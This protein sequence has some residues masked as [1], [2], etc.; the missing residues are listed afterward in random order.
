MS[1]AFGNATVKCANDEWLRFAP[2]DGQTCA[3]YLETFMATAGGYLRDVSA[4]KTCEFCPIKDTNVFL[5]RFKMDYN[6]RWVSRWCLLTPSLDELTETLPDLS[7][8][9]TS[10]YCAPTSASTPSRPSSFTGLR[11]W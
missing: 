11:E 3:A 2:T 6:N 4:M 9:A 8:S 10:A 1:T 5:A 7:L